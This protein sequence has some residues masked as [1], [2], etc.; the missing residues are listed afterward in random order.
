[1]NNVKKSEKKQTNSCLSIYE[2]STFNLQFIPTQTFPT[3]HLIFHQSQNFIDLHNVKVY[4]PQNLLF[5]FV[6][7]QGEPF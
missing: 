5:C 4:A 2:A 3:N 7:L 6:S 1:M